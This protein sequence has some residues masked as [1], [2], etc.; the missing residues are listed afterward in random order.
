MTLL[1]IL[2]VLC[3]LAATAAPGVLL[4]RALAPARGDSSAGR[5]ALVGLA[6]ASIGTRLAPGLAGWPCLTLLLAVATAATLATRGRARAPAPAARAREPRALRAAFALLLALQAASWLALEHR[7]EMPRGWDPSFH[8]LLVE[9]LL[10]GVVPATWDPWE[11]VDVH[12]TLGL[13]ALLA[14]VARL[15]RVPAHEAFEGSYAFLAALLAVETRSL[16]RGLGSGLAGSLG[17]ACGVAFLAHPLRELYDWGGLATL[18]G[19]ATLVA[20]LA[21]LVRVPGRRGLALGAGLAAWLWFAHHLSAL[22]AAVS[23]AGTAGVLFR[24]NGE[25]ARRLL[26]AAA[27][28]AVFALPLVPG[29]LSSAGSLG[30]TSVFRFADEPALEPWRLPGEWGW[31]LCAAALL[32]ALVPRA[33]R[34]RAFGLAWASVLVAAFV[35]LDYVYRG[36]AR[37]LW[38]EDV[39]A[40]TPSRWRMLAALPLALLAGLGL[41]AAVAAVARRRRPRVRALAFVLVLLAPLPLAHEYAWELG[42]PSVDP[43]LI[44]VGRWVR[45]R[46]PEDGLVVVDLPRG[47][48]SETR[49]PVYWFPY[50]TGRET[51]ETPLPASEPRLDPRVAE[52]ASLLEPEV[53]A[54]VAA[55]RS[56]HVYLLHVD[57]VP[58]PAGHWRRVA[59]RPPLALEAEGE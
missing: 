46:V 45:E 27:L 35:S 1:A 47:R 31:G 23:V 25:L 13:H 7:H 10:A 28:S 52:K 2:S 12:Y 58:L 55:R 19:A 48:R 51:N 21:A 39:S 8:V 5:G 11:P 14:H 37:T 49:V 18:L 59:V 54:R 6:L 3:A 30:T 33:R 34:G 41:R 43:E 53:R 15:G 22:I 42:R 36:L 50:L 40:F 24:K 20:A 17:A 57:G 32:G 38:R 4:V 9:R 29:Y 56:K 26:G 16:A 44:E